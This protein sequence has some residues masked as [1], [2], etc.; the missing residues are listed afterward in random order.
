MSKRNKILGFLFIP[1]IV[2]FFFIGWGF[3]WIGSH[4]KNRF[5]KMNNTNKLNYLLRTVERIKEL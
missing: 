3:Y 2:L 4:R 1:I 5:K